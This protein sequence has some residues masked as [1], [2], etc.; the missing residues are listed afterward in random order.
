MRFTRK[1]IRLPHGNYRGKRIYFVTICCHERKAVFANDVWVSRCIARL[2]RVSAAK[3]FAVH[4]FCFMPDHV[5]FLA[6]G[7]GEESSLLAFVSRFKQFTAF[8]YQ[9]KTGSRLWQPKFYDHVL[10]QDIAMDA[11]AWYIWTNPV[12]KGLCGEPR[13]FPY[14]GSMTMIWPRKP[15]TMELWTPPWK[16]NTVPG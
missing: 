10:R 1:N 8:D 16:A 11:V 14:S 9:R 7:L 15:S 13:E 12:R 4:A 6:E 3:G 2:R 5:H